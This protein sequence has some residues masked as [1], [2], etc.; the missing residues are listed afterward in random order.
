MIRAYISVGLPVK[1]CLTALDT[2]PH[3]RGQPLGIPLYLETEQ[4]LNCVTTG[5]LWTPQLYDPIGANIGILKAQGKM[6]L[7]RSCKIA[8]IHQMETP[9]AELDEDFATH[10]LDWL[11]EVQK[12]KGL[13][14][15]K[16][17][18]IRGEKILVGLTCHVDEGLAGLAQ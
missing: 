2:D 5:P 16:R 13:K 9:L 7:S 1:Q 8:T 10:A 3:P 6:V 11:R 17:A 12:I 4:S 14:P 15:I 18:I